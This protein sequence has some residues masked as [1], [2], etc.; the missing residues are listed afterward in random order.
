MYCICIVYIALCRW[1]GDMQLITENFWRIS[2][3]AKI[4]KKHR[5]T[6]DKWFRVLEEEH[7][8][9]YVS[10][11]TN[12]EK[13]YDELDLKIARFIIEYRQKNWSLDAIFDLLPNAFQL[14]SFP[15]DYT[16]ESREL[17]VVEVEKIRAALMQDIKTTLKEIAVT[18]G[19]L[20]LKSIQNVFL[21]KEEQRLEYLNYHF[22]KRR[23]EKKLEQEALSLWLQQPITK[24]YV[25]IGLF[26]KLE[27]ISTR[28]L[29]V[30]AYINERFEKEIKLEYG[31]E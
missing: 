31:I 14:R 28:D 16:E 30:K 18:Q 24:R 8:L 1:R 2:D 5:N 7:F 22:A 10:R 15:E 3:F 29:F 4:L 11:N 21:S 20:Q 12:G 26:Q 23:V 19:D 17:Q 6:I 13:I 9:H 25:K 27:D